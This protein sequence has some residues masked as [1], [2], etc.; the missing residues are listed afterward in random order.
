MTTGGSAVANDTRASAPAAGRKRGRPKNVP[1]MTLV[2]L[3]EH[4][5]RLG[6]RLPLTRALPCTRTTLRKWAKG[7]VA[8]P[9]RWAERIRG[10]PTPPPRPSK[11]AV[12]K[13]RDISPRQLALPFGLA[14]PTPALDAGSGPNAPPALRAGAK[15][16]EAGV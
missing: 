15:R 10:V 9:A 3:G 4:I 6:G 16:V 13:P 7:V 14:R 1:A 5:A 2:E 11:N 12:R 8:I